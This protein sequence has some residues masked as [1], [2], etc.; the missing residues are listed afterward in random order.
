MRMKI[1]VCLLNIFFPDK[2]ECIQI[3]PTLTKSHVV[4]EN[5]VPMPHTEI[6]CYPITNVTRPLDMFAPFPKTHPSFIPFSSPSMSVPQPPNRISSKTN[7]TLKIY[8]NESATGQSTAVA[9]KRHETCYNRSKIGNS[10]KTFMSSYDTGTFSLRKTKR[11]EGIR[12]KS[13]GSTLSTVY[14]QS[15]KE[16]KNHEN[17]T[18]IA[19]KQINRVCSL[20]PANN[21]IRHEGRK[22]SPSPIAFGRSISKERTFAE[23]KKRL[24]LELRKNVPASTSILRDP[25]LKSP[26]AVKK[27]IHN[28]IKSPQHTAYF[29]SRQY[30]RSTLADSTQRIAATHFESNKSLN[31]SID[32]KS[33]KSSMSIS[34]KSLNRSAT[35]L[36]SSGSASKKYTKRSENRSLKSNTKDGR[37]GSNVSL[38]RTSSTFSVNSTTSKKTTH[39]SRKPATIT[40]SPRIVNIPVTIS[41]NKKKKHEIN[42]LNPF[43]EAQKEIAN[44]ND[45]LN[46]ALKC[47]NYDE[48]FESST[49]L[50]ANRSI[51]NGMKSDN[52]FQSLFLRD[53]ISPAPSSM[54][55]NSLRNSL[56]LEKSNFWNN[57]THRSECRVRRPNV[58]LSELRPVSCSK[59]KLL[60]TRQSRSLSPPKV[61]RS[62]TPVTNYQYQEKIEFSDEEDTEG[63]NQKVLAKE[64]RFK[65]E[66]RS[67]SEPRK[68][69]TL[70][71]IPIEGCETVEHSYESTS[72]EV[73]QQLGTVGSRSPSCRRIQ[74]CRSKTTDKEKLLRTR[75][76]G[77]TE[78]YAST[79]SLYDTKVISRSA[80]C[81]NESIY[82]PS[83]LTCPHAKSERFKELNKFYST[84][85]RMRHLEK[86]ISSTDLR[87]IRK[88]GEII[89]YDLWKQVRA[90]ERNE[91]ELKY[92][93]DKLSD[94]QRQKDLNFQPKNPDDLKWHHH[95]DSGLRIK[96]KSVEDLKYAFEEKAMQHELDELKKFHIEASKD[97]YKPYWRGNSVLDSAST[98]SVK[99]NTMPRE[100][101]QDM[102]LRLSDKLVST[103][104]TDQV[105]KLKHQLSEIYNQSVN[106]IKKEPSTSSGTSEKYIITVPPHVVST[107]PLSVR[108]SSMIL[109][110]QIAPGYFKRSKEFKTDQFTS[111]QSRPTP[112]IDHAP[113]SFVAT[114]SK[115]FSESEKREI[116]QTLSRE[117]QEKVEERKRKS[118]S[119]EE[120]KETRGAKA[121]EKAKQSLPDT[122]D[123][124]LEFSCSATSNMPSSKKFKELNNVATAELIKAKQ[125]SSLPSGETKTD[126]DETGTKEIQNKI[127]Y[128]E[129][130]KNEPTPTTIYHARED[131]SPDEEE[132]IKEVEARVKARKEEEK[133]NNSH[134]LSSS[135]T[136]LKE[137]FGERG[138]SRDYFKSNCSSTLK[139]VECRTSSVESLYRSQSLSPGI[140]RTLQTGE[141]RK[142][143][144]KF[145]HLRS[146]TP[147]TCD[148]YQSPRRYRSD[149]DLNKIDYLDKKIPQLR[150]VTIKDHEVGDVS[151]ITHK[152]ETRNNA[153]RGR[154]QIRRYNTSIPRHSFRIEDRFMPH[155][156]IIS[157][158]AA[159]KESVRTAN[160]EKAKRVTSTLV[161]EMRNRFES[162]NY[163][164]I[165]GQMYTSSPD[166]SELRDISNYL[167][168]SW[169][170]HKYPKQNDNYRSSNNTDKHLDDEK[171][172]RRLVSNPRPSSTSPPRSKSYV[173]SILKPYYDIFADQ[174]FDPLKH[175]PKARYVPDKML[176]AE[177]LWQRL[178]MNSINKS[179]VKFQ[180]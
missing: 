66:E 160:E 86:A 38:A 12:S 179:S 101:S 180:G 144:E 145:E 107:S 44:V 174:K 99:Y 146:C 9:T 79:Q 76:A 142:M 140:E 68:H 149:P 100:Q 82:N 6:L 19:R 121:A 4:T 5:I 133:K 48:D 132:V 95:R 162:P 124:F 159:L 98:M 13:A 61:Y 84:L 153:G 33:Y 62:R 127:K 125:L 128:F 117:I 18:R 122:T 70:I 71:N 34:S 41:N 157:K 74:S 92:L 110:N 104:S 166:I 8:S 108:S 154:S 109:E 170:A 65:Y 7:S 46:Y 49:Y 93:V 178:Q 136:D 40:K 135:M 119:V 35:H 55:T 27:A 176:D 111:L 167:T 106:K 177:L 77:S 23:E 151:W 130:K 83:V 143:K 126:D 57:V 60:D 115:T 152:F 25:E 164:S 73:H 26:D 1:S 80:C 96:E 85:E 22:S 43:K 45:A 47:R 16:E 69:V 64:T 175:R 94:D 50:E 137:I 158:I 36:N 163:L 150:T 24:E 17:T 15:V 59:F 56:V 138:S 129:E 52:F 28:Y 97:K 72:D 81:L 31:R 30:R 165:M 148:E 168:G 131:S 53:S 10:D 112:P 171:P 39:I 134:M 89:D 20:S 123:H 139:E 75:S 3:M 141:V 11:G 173:K 63:N 87:P 120:P 42:S 91:K 169:V 14:S 147:D 103:L 161:S 21:L 88:S 2:I 113:S 58:Y 118:E 51:Q 54:T 116:F 78:R 156:D 32:D 67:K 102:K 114:E 29:S 37:N 90:Y 172:K 105:H 155:I